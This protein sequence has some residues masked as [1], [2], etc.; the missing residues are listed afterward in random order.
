MAT[1]KRNTITNITVQT[2]FIIEDFDNTKTN[3][4]I[5]EAFRKNIYHF[6]CSR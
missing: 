6:Q 5:G 4:E 3:I 2:V 1:T